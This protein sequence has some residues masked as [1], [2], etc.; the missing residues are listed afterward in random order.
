MNAKL[1]AKM[2]EVLLYVAATP[3][4]RENLPH[5]G[6]ATNTCAAL[7]TRG[8]ITPGMNIWDHELTDFGREALAEAAH[9]VLHVEPI[10][11]APAPLDIPATIKLPVGHEL[12]CI[13]GKGSHSIWRAVHTAGCGLRSSGDHRGY[14]VGQQKCKAQANEHTCPAADGAMPST[15]AAPTATEPQ[16]RKTGAVRIGNLKLVTEQG[17]PVLFDTNYTDRGATFAILRG[18]NP[19]PGTEPTL[20]VEYRGSAGTVERFAHRLFDGWRWIAATA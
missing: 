18:V 6:R 4:Q 20:I 5:P 14:R 2:T 12:I 15:P 7:V 16:Q 19:I 9:L 17:W 13:G 10:T 11:E 3:A 1:T 8:L